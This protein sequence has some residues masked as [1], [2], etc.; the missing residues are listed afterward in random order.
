M[1]SSPILSTQIAALPW[2]DCLQTNVRRLATAAAAVIGLSAMASGASGSTPGLPNGT[3]LYGESP[4]A[5]TAGAV[6]FVFEA[7]AGRLSGAIYQPS[8]SFDC[9]RGTVGSDAID[10]IITDAYNQTESPY[11]AAL[12]ADSTV[13]SASEGAVPVQLEGM[14]AIANL[15]ELDH[16][17][18]ATCSDR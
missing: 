15:S 10:L 7:Q 12:V 4:A 13:A 14:H 6:Y 2:G 9:V 17:L 3:Y 5:D 18:L 8:S 16:R 1:A 11:S